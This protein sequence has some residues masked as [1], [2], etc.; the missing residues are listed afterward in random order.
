MPLAIHNAVAGILDE[1][2]KAASIRPRIS[3]ADILD[4]VDAYSHIERRQSLEVLPYDFVALKCCKNIVVNPKIHIWQHGSPSISH[5]TQTFE[6]SASFFIKL[7]PRTTLAT[8]RESTPYNALAGFDSRIYPA[9]TQSL[10]YGIEV[11]Q[12]VRTL[13]C[14]NPY[15]SLCG[16]IFRQPISPLFTRSCM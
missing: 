6:S 15:L 10:L 4:I 1:L 13:G 2:L 12:P 7:G 8:R 3:L 11:L 14:R 9:E 16:V 5:K